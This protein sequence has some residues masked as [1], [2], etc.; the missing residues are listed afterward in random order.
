VLEPSTA[1]ILASF[2]NTPQKS[3]AITVN[4]FGKGRAIYLATAAQP[5]FIGPLIRSLYPALGI[6]PGPVTP[7]GVSARTVEGRTL[8][9]NTKN[10]PVTVNFNGTK[11]SVLTH[12]TYAGKIDLPAYGVELL[13]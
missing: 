9:V 11:L 8:Y 7:D 12:K 2:S 1:S 10:S 13:Q 3:P 6:K 5:E 4:K